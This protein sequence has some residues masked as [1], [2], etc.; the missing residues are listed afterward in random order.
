MFAPVSSSVPALVFVNALAPDTTPDNVAVLPDATWIVEL[1]FSSTF[2]DNVA[3]FVTLSAPAAEYPAPFSVSG[4][5]VAYPAFVRVAPS[6]T[7]VPVD[8]A[9]SAPA[10]DIVKVPWETVVTPV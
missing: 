3:S 2:P 5:E 7:V 1:E 9:P 6:E 10:L 8:E 4:S